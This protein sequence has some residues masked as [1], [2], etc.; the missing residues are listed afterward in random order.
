MINTLL[1]LVAVVTCTI[2][3]PVNCTI[4]PPD[5]YTYCNKSV[6]NTE[7]EESLD[8]LYT[9]SDDMID[10]LETVCTKAVS[11][12][13]SIIYVTWIF[14]KFQICGNNYGIYT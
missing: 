9:K 11:L 5:L 7:L 13:F 12:W 4:Q 10:L 8:V 14:C 2:A 3:A 1:S 6:N